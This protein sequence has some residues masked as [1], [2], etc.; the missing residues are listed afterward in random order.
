MLAELAEDVSDVPAPDE[1]EVLVPFSLVPLP[2][3]P[4]SLPPPPSFEA[5]P[6]FAAPPSVLAE[7]SL[8]ARRPW[9][10]PPQ[11]LRA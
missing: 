6:S 5:P 10:S 7:A 3:V 2:L 4:L 9:S 1:L 11:D 8:P